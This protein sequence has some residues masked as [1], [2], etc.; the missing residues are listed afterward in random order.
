MAGVEPDTITYVEAHGSGTPLGDPIEIRALTRAFR[1]GHRA[2]G[3]LRRG[4]G[5]DQHRP[6]ATRR[7]GVAG[8]IKTVLALEHRLIPPSLHFTGANPE[9]G[10]E[11][12]PFRV[13]TRLA[14]WPVPDGQPRRA[15]VSSFGMGGTNAHVVLEEAP[16]PEP[17]G[18]GPGH[19]SSWSSRRP[20]PAAL[21]AARPTA[22]PVHLEAHPE[23]SLADVA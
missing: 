21:D 8:L 17:V 23:T 12:T 9:I 10:F 1:A 11:E 20:P 4:L 3:L 15:G 2:D 19:G 13:A 22:S 16:E 7:P 5:Q 14:D 18:A 6:P